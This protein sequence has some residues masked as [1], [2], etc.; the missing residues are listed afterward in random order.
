MGTFK[1]SCL[2]FFALVGLINTL[3]LATL[4]F[5]WEPLMPYAV[6]LMMQPWFGILEAVLLAIT[7][8]G[9]FTL[10]VYSIAATGTKGQLHS[11]Q[12]NGTITI[13]RKALETTTR[14]A[15]ENHHGL[16]AE[17]I[18]V[19]IRGKRNARIRIKAKIDSGARGNLYELGNTLQ[20]EI[21]NAVEGFSGHLVEEVNVTFT[22]ESYKHKTAE[23]GSYEYTNSQANHQKPAHG[24]KTQS[25][26]V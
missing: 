2:L 11:T 13:T 4:W 18:K 17:T 10:L 22:G 8:I 24:L 15:I 14:H 21:V 3:F 12:E 9:L 19:S 7:A 25:A 26:T 23:G 20:N 5:A 6:W 16:H 1:R